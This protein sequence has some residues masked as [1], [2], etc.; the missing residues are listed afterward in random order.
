MRCA[1]P[2]ELQLAVEEFGAER[3]KPFADAVAN[4]KAALAQV[5]G[6]ADPRRRFAGAALESSAAC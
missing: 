5:L 6:P 4:A 2:S 3:T 1:P